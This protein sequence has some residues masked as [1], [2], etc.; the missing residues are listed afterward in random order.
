MFQKNAGVQVVQN[1]V[2]EVQNQLDLLGKSC[3]EL[4]QAIQMLEMRLNLVIHPA[5]HIANYENTEK[6]F[7]GVELANIIYNKRVFISNNIKA[8]TNIIDRIDL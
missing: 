7:E 2:S 5:E 8:I 1:K 4:A 6:A 3:E